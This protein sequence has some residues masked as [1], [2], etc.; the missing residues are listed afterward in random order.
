VQ[1]L[2]GVADASEGAAGFIAKAQKWKTGSSL[3]ECMM[4]LVRSSSSSSSIKHNTSG[5]IKEKGR[6]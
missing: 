6:K 4:I 5:V 1:Y 3:M 2:I